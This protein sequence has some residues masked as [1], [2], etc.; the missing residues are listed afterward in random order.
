MN[1]IHVIVGL[2]ASGAELFLQRLSFEQRNANYH[3]TVISLTTEGTLGEALRSRGVNVL[4]LGLSGVLSVP[5]VVYKLRKHISNIRP[6]I[7]QSWM[8][9][10]DF[11]SSLAMFGLN[12][13][14]IWSVRC[15]NIPAGSYFTLAL[16]KI[17]SLLSYVSPARVCYVAEASKVF[18]QSQGYSP[19]KSITIANGYDFSSLVYSEKKR[20]SFRESLSL[21]KHVTV[22]GLVGRFHKDKGQDIL[23]EAFSKL[24]ADIS[25]YKILLVGREC[26]NDNHQLVNLINSYGLDENVILLGE[27]N[28]I[29]GLLSAMDIYVMGSRTEGFPNALAEAMSIG[30]PC[31]ATNVGD[32]A[33]LADKYAILSEANSNSLADAILA[34]VKMPVEQRKML[35]IHAADH[36]RKSFSIVE[37]KKLY[38][39]LY[40][41]LLE[42]K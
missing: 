2:P 39:Q 21:D 1:I 42:K 32:A 38:D 25:N 15:S 8:Y 7:I 27:Q 36:V 19:K 28:D 14:L 35:G 22:F 5:L 3:I 18:H 16:M 9:H 31:I 34:V 33:L 24:K 11:F 20:N 4:F 26:N 37:I 13:K 30:L 29:S 10:A 23:L 40:H 41:S 17:C 6:D 12:K